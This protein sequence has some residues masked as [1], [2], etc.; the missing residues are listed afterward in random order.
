MKKIL[1]MI[2]LL[3]CI[4]FSNVYANELPTLTVGSFDAS[5]GEEITIPIT[6]E[7]NRDGFACIGL[8]IGYDS[9]NLEYVSAKIKGL[10][11]AQMKDISNTNDSIF[12]YALVYDDDKI[13]KDNGVIAEIKF[14][15]KDN[16]ITSDLKVVQLDYGDKELNRLEYKVNDGKIK[17]VEKEKKSST[18][19]LSSLIENKENKK[20]KW[21]SSDNKIAIVDKDGKVTFKNNGTTVITAED[22]DGNLLLE[23]EYKV[24]SKDSK[25]D[26]KKEISIVG[27]LV[28]IFLVIV[29][30]IAIIIFRKKNK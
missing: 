24:T 4:L 23:K 21:K 15:V 12:L 7:N 8:K 27:I 20:I 22:D 16:A 19:D 9:K 14:K 28:F 18:K 26:N 1:G 30:I 6:L 29:S 17:I 2:L 3:I 13:L 10:K 25:N 11:E 5:I